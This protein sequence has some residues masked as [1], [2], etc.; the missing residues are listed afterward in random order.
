MVF[1]YRLISEGE[2]VSIETEIHRRVAGVH[3]CDNGKSTE[4]ENAH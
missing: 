2:G 3:E 4:P 1:E